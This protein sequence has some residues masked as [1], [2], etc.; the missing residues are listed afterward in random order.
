MNAVNVRPAPNIFFFQTSFITFPQL[1]TE[2]TYFQVECS[3]YLLI[4]LMN[5]MLYLPEIFFFS[6]LQ[7]LECK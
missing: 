2:N 7:V 1:Y 3:P 6:I 5:M 4:L